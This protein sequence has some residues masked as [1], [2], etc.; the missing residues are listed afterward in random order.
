VQFAY[1]TFITKSVDT[2]QRV[3]EGIASSLTPDRDGD[4]I[5]PRGA[6]FRLPMPLLWQHKQEQPIG[7]VLEAKL[8]DAGWYIRAQIA[9]GLTTTIEDAWRL[10]SGGLAKGFSVGMLPRDVEPRKG[11]RYGLHVKSWDWLETSVVTIGSNV[12]ASILVIKSLDSAARAALGARRVDPS[13]GAAGSLTG[14]RTMNPSEQITALRTQLQ[15]KHAR[16]GELLKLETEDGVELNDEQTTEVDGLT[17]DVGTL[18]TR[19]KRL[20]VMEASSALLASP[21]GGTTLD[22]ATKARMGTS[23]I[24]EKPDPTP[25][26]IG[27]ARAA[28]CKMAAHLSGGSYTALEIARHKYPNDGRIPLMLKAAIDIGTTTDAG[29]AGNLVYPNQ[30]ASEFVEYLRPQT[31]VGQFGLN[32]IPSLR[33]VPFNVRITG[34]A[35]G[36]S[37]SWVGQGLAKP[38]TQFDTSASSLGFTKI[39]TIAVLT[40]E[41]AK[42]SSPNAETMVRDELAAAVIER[43]DQDFINPAI[44]AIADVR[45]ASILS[46]VTPVTM[47]GTDGDA[48]RAALGDLLAVYLTANNS[49]R[50]AVIILPSTLALE[51]SLLTNALGQPE[52]PSLSMSGG[53]LQG[54]P[55]ITSQYASIGGFSLFIMVNASDIFLADDGGVSVD[56]SREATVLMSN[57]PVADAATGTSVNLWQN[58]L[59]GLRAERFVNW[60]KRRAGAAQYIS[61]DETPGP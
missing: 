29:W 34:Q 30:L 28:I 50:S 17:A 26:G 3:I 49:P 54:I 14:L 16:L 59:I 9:K 42:F 19:I 61:V 45:P 20:E 12:D 56:V 2:E 52:F 44:S 33:R 18:G 24:V 55:V 5:D 1:S 11:K 7:E 15:T 58:N 10:I 32:G 13:P 53:T 23:R 6:K 37:A 48:V 46:G 21:V 40:Q 39:A 43:M 25:P 22:L 8:T 27:F 57:D 60:A 35:T 51:W 38:V 31:I 47:T 4:V 36:A 41:L